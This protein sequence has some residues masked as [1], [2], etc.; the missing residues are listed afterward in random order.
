[1]ES[2]AYLIY[3]LLVSFFALLGVIVS[4]QF[5]FRFIRWAFASSNKS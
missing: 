5:L 4:F 1:M 2:T 3:G